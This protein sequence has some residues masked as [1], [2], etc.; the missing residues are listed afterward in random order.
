MIHCRNCRCE[1]PTFFRV[2][3]RVWRYYVN[4]PYRREILC[5]GCWEKIV[6]AIDGGAYQAKYGRPQ[7]IDHAANDEIHLRDIERGLER[8][9]P[10]RNT[11]IGL[12]A[13]DWRLV[14]TV[15]RQASRDPKD[16]LSF[17]AELIEHELQHRPKW[18][19]LEQFRGIG[20]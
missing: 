15:L 18:P 11:L 1:W 2:P 14:C 3:T 10:H 19:P 4:P 20:K 6:Q 17:I 16:R 9:P 13:K 7:V 5:L 8:F 12:G